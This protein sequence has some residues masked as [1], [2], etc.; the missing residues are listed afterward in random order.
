MNIVLQVPETSTQQGIDISNESPEWRIWQVP[1]EMAPSREILNVLSDPI[2]S[3]SM[4]S[5]MIRQLGDMSR[6]SQ[7]RIQNTVVVH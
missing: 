1:A 2:A 7:F 4:H 6:F 5:P 3:M